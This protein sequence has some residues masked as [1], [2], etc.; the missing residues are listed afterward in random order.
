[1][2][3]FILLALFAGALA[4]SRLDED[5]YSD[6]DLR[7]TNLRA[8]FS[9]FILKYN[10]QGGLK[11]R[12]EIKKR[13]SVFSKNVKGIRSHNKFS[14][15]YRQ[16]INKFADMTL[17][18]R[19]KFTGLTNISNA[20]LE[21]RDM[22]VT[23]REMLEVRDAPAAY[24][25]RDYGHVSEVTNQGDCG[26]C[27]TYG[28]VYPLEAEISILSG[29]RAVGLSQQEILSC[30]YEAKPDR[31]GC[32]GG[33]YMDG[34]KYVQQ[35]GHLSTAADEP[36]LGID[37]DCDPDM[38][39]KPNAF[40]RYSVSSWKQV[41]EQDDDALAMFGSKHVIAVAVE[42]FGLFFYEDGR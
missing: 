20:N 16:G 19:V 23:K 32:Q 27:W 31:N 7:D 17:H 34:W 29:K 25:H 15:G 10:K 11:S 22:A 6:V 40:E 37:M 21:R 30:A 9:G 26:S 18:E 33:W 2:K 5:D 8:E 35:S 3:V 39:D 24:D 36:Y 38:R 14:G 4:H 28:V 41:P 42:S 12:S 13:Y 1:M